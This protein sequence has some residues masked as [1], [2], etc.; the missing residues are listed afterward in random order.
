MKNVRT[1][2]EKMNRIDT[3]SP[4]FFLPFILVL[5]FFT[6]L[7]DFHRFEL[8]NITYSIWPS[9]IVALIFYYIGVY[10]ID[11][12]GW[13]FPSFGLAK[14]GKYVVHFIV[15]LML[16]G[17]V[18]YVLITIKAGFGLADESVRR[19]LP[20]KLMFFTHLLWFGALLLLSYRMVKEKAMTWKKAI[21]YAAAFAVVMSLFLL[22][23]YRTPLV[24]MLFTGII[25]FHYTVQRVKLTW[26]LSALLII[27]ITFSMF[28]FLRVV[29]EDTSKEFNNRDQPDISELSEDKKERLVTTEQKVNQ[30]PK[31]IRGLNGES[32]TG[33]IVLSR[34][35]EY[36][37][38]NGY[39]NGEIHAGV[40]NTILPGE[41]VSP[42]MRVTQIVNSLSVKDGKFITRENRTT[43]PTFI[44]QLF[45]DGGYLLV[46]IGF[47]LYGA[48]V[49]MVY[50]KV[51]QGGTHTFHT[52]AYAFVV[53]MFTISMHTGLL[54]LIFVL[55]LGFVILASAIIKT[56]PKS[57]SGLQFNLMK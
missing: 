38:E 15:G 30:T 7:F 27:G 21:I 31:W 37:D 14:L 25:V 33:H 29:T 32:V 52:V 39:L 9:V 53:T 40:F 19:N 5:Y 47:L 24:L 56:E 3:F 28:G 46:A 44:G 35:I 54:D 16:I 48:V 34:I 36:T 18:A 1:L 55:M 10:V 20:P 41:Q 50:N 11:R 49:S 26:F 8:F 23:G 22:M 51:K 45:L 2:L 17:L 6:S 57:A 12:L 42:R 4:Y 13:T 43:T